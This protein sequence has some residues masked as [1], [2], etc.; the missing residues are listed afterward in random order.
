MSGLLY[1]ILGK[2]DMLSIMIVKMSLTVDTL[3]IIKM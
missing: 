3:S 2:K 1:V